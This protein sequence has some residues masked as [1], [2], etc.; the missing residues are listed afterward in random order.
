MVTRLIL[1]LLVHS[2]CWDACCLPTQQP[3]VPYRSAVVGSYCRHL[4][5]LQQRVLLTPAAV[6]HCCLTTRA[7]PSPAVP[8]A[9][10]A[11]LTGTTPLALGERFATLRSWFCLPTLPRLPLP[12][13]PPL[14]QQLPA[15]VV[16]TLPPLPPPGLYTNGRY[17]PPGCTPQL[18]AH[19]NSQTSGHCLLPDRPRS[20]VLVLPVLLAPAVPLPRSVVVDW[21][22]FCRAT[23]LT[24]PRQRCRSFG[25][26]GSVAAP[27]E[28]SLP[29]VRLCPLDLCALL[30]G[31]F[32]RHTTIPRNTYVV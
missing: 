13:P 3:C 24:L 5:D 23:V 18:P 12:Q 7:C 11:D 22:P 6:S 20:R 4:P 28:R 9:C 32:A 30:A 31:R 1:R 10:L 26:T 27:R 2:H 14:C 25:S 21:F 16:R 15:C 17:L 8:R 19:V 29:T